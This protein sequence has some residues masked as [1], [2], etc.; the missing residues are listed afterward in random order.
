MKKLGEIMETTK[1]EKTLAKYWN[2]IEKFRGKK[3]LGMGD[4]RAYLSALV[5]IEILNSGMDKNG[6]VSILNNVLNENSAKN[7][8]QDYEK[9]IKTWVESE[10]G[11]LRGYLQKIKPPQVKSEKK[12]KNNGFHSISLFSG[13][14]GLDLGF[15]YAGF[16]VDVALDI[17][18]ASKEIISANRPK[19]PFI[20]DDVANVDTR[21][22]LDIAGVDKGELDVLTGGPPCQP[23]STAGKRD[24]LND[25]RASPLV[26]YIRVINEAKP[27]IFVMEEVTG[28]L[29][30]RLVHVP[31]KERKD[32]TLLPE[33]EKGSVWKVITEELRK[34][35]YTIRYETLNAADYG[36][37]E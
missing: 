36:T 8:S 21:T 25:P 26:E 35:G 32:R 20:L 16:E 37:S 19:V 6:I 10:K 3:G 27:K 7:P 17:E 13:S 18:P 24:G 14:F 23:F 9:V 28:L 1:E 22:I 15:E 30:A 2:F 29:N 5:D 4:V 12:Y 33:E 11:D 34:T 31:I